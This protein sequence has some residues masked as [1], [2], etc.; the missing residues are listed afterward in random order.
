MKQVH[1]GRSTRERMGKD[2]A[3]ARIKM[4]EVEKITGEI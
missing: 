3:E 2:S 1:R 4:S